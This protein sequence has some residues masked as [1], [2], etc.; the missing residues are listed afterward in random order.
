MIVTPQ[1]ICDILQQGMDLQDDQIW[2]Y[3]QRKT[4]PYDKRLYVSVSVIAIKP[5]A[6]N[7]KF[8][9]TTNKDDT[10]QYVQE[11][12]SINLYSYT[13]EALER[14]HEVMGS[15]ISTYSQQQQA[16]LALQIA[17]VPVAIN[18]VSA[19]ESTTILYRI[20]ITLPVLRKYD[21]LIT[22]QYYDT[23]NDANVSLTQT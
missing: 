18:D 1:I 11:T 6:N 19:V 17:R 21:K 10:S 23:F 16:L 15:L 22:A 2:I 7:V 3:N 20:A 4:I 13:T 8:N 9:S 5:Y 12:L 14:Y